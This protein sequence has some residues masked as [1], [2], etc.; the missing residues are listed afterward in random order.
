MSRVNF[1]LK[2]FTHE[3]LGHRQT[4]EMGFPRRQRSHFSSKLFHGC[5]WIL[6][7]HFTTQVIALLSIVL[8]QPPA[9]WVAVIWFCYRMIVTTVLAV[10]LVV[11]VLSYMFCCSQGCCEDLRLE[12]VVVSM[13]TFRKQDMSFHHI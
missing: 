5:S 12:I 1:P 6:S 11:P 3:N 4:F 2:N 13:H 7:N 8:G 10:V 9:F